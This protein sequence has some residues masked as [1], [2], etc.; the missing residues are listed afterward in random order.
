MATTKND[1]RGWLNEGKRKNATH[2]IVMC[3]TFD[4][5][6]YP[7]YIM[8]GTSAR[9]EGTKRTGNMQ[10]VMEC[11]SLALDFESQLNEVRSFHWD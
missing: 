8:P 11:Y 5:G 3:D 7:V 10:R 4:Y 9:E 2:V 1:I 6:D